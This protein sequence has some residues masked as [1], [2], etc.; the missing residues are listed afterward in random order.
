MGTTGE[1][2]TLDMDPVIQ[3]FSHLHP[4][5]LQNFRPQTTNSFICAGCNLDASGRFYFCSTC[6]YCLHIT[7]SRMPRNIEHQVDP[8]HTL[9]LLSS[10]VYAAGS[11]KCNA[12]GKLGTAFCYHCKDCQL[13]IHTLCIYKPSSVNTST[14]HHTLELCFSPPYRKKKFQCDICK[15]FGSNHWLYRCGS[16]KYDVHMNCAMANQLQTATEIQQTKQ[17]ILCPPASPNTQFQPATAIQTQQT[18]QEQLLC[19]ANGPRSQLQPV[20]GGQQTHQL[21]CHNIIASNH[22]QPVT[23]IQH[24]KEQNLHQSNSANM[25]IQ[26]IRGIQLQQT[27]QEQLLCHSGRANTCARPITGIQQIQQQP[28]LLKCQSFPPRFSKFM[29]DLP[30]SGPTFHRVSQPVIPIPQQQFCVPYIQTPNHFPEA[31]SSNWNQPY[32]VNG[33]TAI[34][35]ALA[36]RQHVPQPIHQMNG[37]TASAPTFAAVPQ[38]VQ[39]PNT[40]KMGNNLMGHVVQELVDSFIQQAG[41]AIFE[42]ITSGDLPLDL[43]IGNS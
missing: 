37:Y 31:G 28:Q 26:P 5:I 6:N 11:F 29:T 35:P 15:Q 39:S 14:H 40:T 13:D 20:T 1:M 36:A 21:L 33:Y 7:C 38:Y 12:C 25:Q 24:T 17:R 16:C 22:P 30:N 19:Q 9:V 23:G 42:S 8:K 43:D 27:H 3:H 34:M 18:H 4:L 41:G 10:P 2:G 32:K